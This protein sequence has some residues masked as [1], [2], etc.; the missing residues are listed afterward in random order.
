VE[1]I[2]AIPGIGRALITAI[3]ARDLPTIQAG[4]LIMAATYAG[5]NLLAD[6]AVAALDPRIRYD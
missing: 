3:S 1:E 2:F 6:I 4:A 5:A